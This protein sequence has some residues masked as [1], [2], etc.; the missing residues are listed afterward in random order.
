ML[1]REIIM[2][3]LQTK[4]YNVLPADVTKNGVEM[5]GVTIG[6][7]KVRPTIYINDFLKWTDDRLDEVVCIIEDMYSKTQKN[8]PQID[9]ENIKDWDYIKTRL[10]VCVQKKGNEDIVK[11][12]FLDLELYVRVIVD[13][14]RDEEGCVGSFKVKPEHIKMWNV[15]ESVLFSAA[16]DCTKPTLV[17]E[18]MAKIISQMLGKN[19]AEILSE[20]GSAPRQIILSN[21]TRINGAVAMCDVWFLKEIADRLESDL[22]IFPSSIHECIVT[23]MDGILRRNELDAMV[24]NINETQVAPEEVLSNHAYFFNR[25]TMEIGW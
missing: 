5:Q 19:E 13:T 14:N 10:Q 7:G 11:K 17:E 20:M 23:P 8:T 3:T 18:D 24:K 6:E 1:T 12:D 22:V 4:G 25:N 16:W 9:I 2:N 21:K 15:D